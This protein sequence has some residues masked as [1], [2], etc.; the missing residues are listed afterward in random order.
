MKEKLK[1]VTLW[2]KFQHISREQYLP[3]DYVHKIKLKFL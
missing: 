3:Q 1:G 2:V